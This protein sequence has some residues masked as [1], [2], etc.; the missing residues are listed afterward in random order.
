M[1]SCLWLDA[2]SSSSE[3]H[4]EDDDDGSPEV[5]AV[6]PVKDWISLDF[7]IV[8]DQAASKVCRQPAAVT[9]FVCMTD[10]MQSMHGD[11]YCTMLHL[12]TLL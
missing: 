9:A 4:D 8:R 2:S 5:F 12:W 6:R 11:A 10:D 7:G 3:E 1:L